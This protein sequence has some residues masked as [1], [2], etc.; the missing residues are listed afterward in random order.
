MKTGNPLF[1][2]KNSK[3]Q[4]RV[5][6]SGLGTPSTAD[7]PGI[8]SLPEWANLNFPQFPGK[9]IRNLVPQLDDVS[10]DL[11]SVRLIFILFYSLL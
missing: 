11:I 2:G 1:P 6:F 10:A 3:D 8:T 4:I 7:Y 9:G 5:I